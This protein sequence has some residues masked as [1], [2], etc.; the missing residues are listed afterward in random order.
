MPSQKASENRC[1]KKVSKNEAN[2]FQ[3]DAK[4]DAEIN[5]FHVFLQKAKSHEMFCFSI[6]NV[7]LGMQKGIKIQ[8]K[9]DA[10]SMLE[11]GIEK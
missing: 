7:V 11:K 1:R 10:K 5:D 6:W 9:F 3:N 8:S 4:M 2:R